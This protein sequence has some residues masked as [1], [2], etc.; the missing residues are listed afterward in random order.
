M[1][2]RKKQIH[3]QKFFYA[4]MK[5]ILIV[6][7]TPFEIQPFMEFLKQSAQIK[8]NPL[9][10]QNGY[11]FDVLITGVGIANTALKLGKTLSKKPYDFALNAGIA[12]SFN[13]KI[14]RGDVVEVV[15]EQYGDLGVEEADGR[16]SDMFETGL[17]DK[18]EK[19]FKDGKL[20]NTKPLK[21]KTAKL[22]SGL[23]VQKVHGFTDSIEAVLAKY[24]T[25]IET[26]EGAAFFQ[27]CLTEGVAFCQIRAIS[28]YVEPRNRENWKLKEAI[29]NLNAYLIVLFEKRMI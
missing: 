29:E 1:K 12:G 7:A 19:P 25:D 26:M 4:S 28:N 13:R 11:E 14:L 17:M 2:K 10:G 5:K 22:V 8:Y 16:F 23:T 20:L 6:A 27:A 21:L 15:S 3:L 18:D 24:R 9:F